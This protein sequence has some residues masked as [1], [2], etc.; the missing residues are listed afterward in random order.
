MYIENHTYRSERDLVD[1]LNQF[2]ILQ[3]KKMK[4]ICI[5]TISRLAYWSRAKMM[6]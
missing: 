1:Y 6:D 3:M 4:L 2:L 5:V